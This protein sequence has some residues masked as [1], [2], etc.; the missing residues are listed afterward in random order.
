MSIYRQIKQFGYLAL[1]LVG[2]NAYL[3]RRNRDRIRVFALHGVADYG[4]DADWVP[5][6]DQMPVDKLEQMIRSLAGTYHFIPIDRAV[7]I[8]IGDE[9]AVP[10]GAVL[11]F[12]DGYR[13]NFEQALPVLR[14]YTVPA[15][16]YIATDYVKSRRPFWF[17]RLDYVIQRA[18]SQNVC[19]EVGERKFRFEDAGREA[20]KHKFAELRAYCKK[21]HDDEDEFL[22]VLDGLAEKLESMTDDSLARIL[23]E[24]PWAAV[25]SD[26]ELARVA[27]DPLVT[28]GSHTVNHLRLAHA[29]L[30]YVR[31]ELTASKRMLEQWT[32]A[33][34][35][36]FAYPNGAYDDVSMREVELAGYASAVTSDSGMNEAGDNPYALTRLNLNADG[37]VAE[38]LARASGLEDYVAGSLRKWKAR[39]L[40]GRAP[41]AKTA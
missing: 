27:K 19:L 1:D 11:T 25:V 29:G 14:K 5:L 8:L 7:R 9:P 23:D 13:N 2:A 16:F 26:E 41:A 12:D 15:T 37:T 30:D 28:I 4:V 31:F 3:R 34:V 24:D 17:D 22:A 10:N 40:P 18:A 36:H 33:E 39:L 20:V 32:G 35:R 21:S 38:M 6:R